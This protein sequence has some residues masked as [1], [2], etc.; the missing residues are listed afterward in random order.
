[1]W[2][3]FTAASQIGSITAAPLCLVSAPTCGGWGGEGREGGVHGSYSQTAADNH[4]YISN[5]HFQE[6]NLLA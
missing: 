6:D 5:H 3:Q 2:S 4:A 1:M